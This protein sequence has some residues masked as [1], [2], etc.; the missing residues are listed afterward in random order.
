MPKKDVAARPS[1]ARTWAL[2]A[3]RSRALASAARGRAFDEAAARMGGS[4]RHWRQPWQWLGAALCTE[5]ASSSGPPHAHARVGHRLSEMVF[6]RLFSRV[7]VLGY[8]S[9]WGLP[10]EV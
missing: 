8:A 1:A 6:L 10:W 9:L 2:R 4:R 7:W 5:G 3:Q